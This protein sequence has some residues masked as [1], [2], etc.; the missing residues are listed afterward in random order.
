MGKKK[1]CS[2]TKLQHSALGLRLYPRHGARF[3]FLMD[4][5]LVNNT[6][7]YLHGWDTG[8][9]IKITQQHF[10]KIPQKFPN[11]HPKV[12]YSQMLKHCEKKVSHTKN[13]VRP[14]DPESFMLS[15]LQILLVSTIGNVQ[16]KVWRICILMLR[17]EGL[18]NKSR[19]SQKCLL[20]LLLKDMFL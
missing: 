18:N 8:P 7:I 6:T 4:L 16:R 20:T 9:S 12:Y 19:N 14:L 3:E 13:R 10:I 5:L 1:L 15:S 2:L 11:T 17:C